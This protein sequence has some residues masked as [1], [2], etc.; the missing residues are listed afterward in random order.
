VVAAAGNRAGRAP[1][2][3]LEQAPE[4]DAVADSVGPPVDGAV[5]VV[6]SAAV[7]SAVM[8]RAQQKMGALQPADRGDAGG[9][10]PEPM[11]IGAEKHD[12]GDA[13]TD[14]HGMEGQRRRR[15]RER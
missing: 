13:A 2:E 6:V 3:S 5:V 11:T 9:P 1:Y 15:Q 8:P 7:M 12:G 10:V 14:E 4:A